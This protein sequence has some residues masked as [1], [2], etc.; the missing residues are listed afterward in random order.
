[1]QTVILERHRTRTD[2]AKDSK[3]QTDLRATAAKDSKRQAQTRTASIRNWVR[4]CPALRPDMRSEDLFKLFRSQSEL[5]CVAVIDD[6][7]KPVGLIMKRQFYRTIGSLYGLSLY[8]EK[9]IDV[10][11]DASPLIVDI[12]VHPQ[13][14]IDR[15]LFREEETFYDAVLVTEQNR[16]TGM[17]M[18]SDLLQVSRQLQRESFDRQ[19]QTVQETKAML[20]D[21]H[22]AIVQ[23]EEAGGTVRTSGEHIESLTRQGKTELEEMLRLFRQW[24]DNAYRQEQAV[25]Q[26]TERMAKADHIVK[27]IVE[28]ADQCNLL[29]VNATIEAARA[30][31][32]GSGFGVVANEVRSLADQ[33][34][35]SAGQIN[36]LLSA[37]TEAAEGAAAL[38][39]EG[40]R[41]ADQGVGQVASAEETFGRLWTSTEHNQQAARR[42]IDD[43]REAT[44]ISDNVRSAFD[45]LISQ[46]HNFTQA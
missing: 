32:Y 25:A 38:V 29:A 44:G 26:L 9:G 19:I 23:V 33:T 21:I 43:A 17:L 12:G 14:L 31:E 45:R 18:V 7:H 35:Q 8:R 6:T 27:L 22:A 28:L 30:S 34:K 41:G 1:M 42:L 5:E 40:K 36:R 20:G 13:S 46:I 2:A 11:M 10:L 24:S 15:A 4:S 39:R 3:Q 37:M 16:F